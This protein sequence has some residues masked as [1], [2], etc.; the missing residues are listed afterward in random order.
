[1]LKSFLKRISSS[2]SNTSLATS[3]RRKRFRYFLNVIEQIDK[4]SI[5]ILDV[6][7]W[8]KFWE[9]QDFADSP[10]QI[11]LL[12]LEQFQ[13]NHER[14]SSVVGNAADMNQFMDK[15]FDIV[16]SN[17]VIEHLGTIENQIK[18]ANE[19]RRIGKRYFIQT[20]SYYFPFEPHFL[21]PFFH[22][23]TKTFR[24]FLVLHFSLGHYKRQESREQA[25]RLV[26][27]HR[28]LKKRE[29]K[30]LFPDAR[31]IVERFFG[32][33]KSYIAIKE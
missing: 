25:E 27:E 8:E 14:I 12:N 9:I 7:G 23:F 29:L 11:T 32:L 6:G 18:M 15:S 5:K 20:P 2:T 1:M 19:V 3:F 4:T 21:F 16:F 17:S 28:L 30:S 22:W 24:I 10:H 26:N 33:S 31:I 13:T